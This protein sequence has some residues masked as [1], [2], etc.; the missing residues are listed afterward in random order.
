MHCPFDS[1]SNLKDKMYVGH[2]HSRGIS[3]RA[4][5]N[6]IQT[7]LRYSIFEKIRFNFSKISENFAGINFRERPEN[8]D[9][10]DIS[11]RERPKNSRNRESFYPRN[12]LPLKY[13]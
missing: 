7:V 1:T 3:N 6:P 11:F 13:A 12:F 8:Y 10:A 5:G 4:N 2:S 9:F